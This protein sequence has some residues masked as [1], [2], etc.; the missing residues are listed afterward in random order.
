M[1]VHNLRR[2]LIYLSIS[3]IEV[4]LEDNR[5]RDVSDIGHYGTGDV[6]LR[7][8]NKEDILLAKELIEKAYNSLGS[9]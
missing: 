8:K 3:P 7:I 9:W 5:V 1:R 2:R 4:N 6:E